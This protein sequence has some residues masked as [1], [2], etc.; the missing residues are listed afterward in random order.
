MKTVTVREF[1]HNAGLVDGLAEGRQLLVTANGSH[2]CRR[3]FRL[4]QFCPCIYSTIRPRPAPQSGGRAATLQP[5]RVGWSTEALRN[6]KYNSPDVKQHAAQHVPLKARTPAIVLRTDRRS[7]LNYEPADHRNSAEPQCTC[8]YR[9]AWFPCVRSPWNAERQ[10]VIKA[11][12]TWRFR[13]RSLA[14]HV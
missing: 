5:W 6:N 4:P 10:G 12:L 11:V 14:M 3:S 9:P 7:A 8:D 2:G 1:Y 13:I